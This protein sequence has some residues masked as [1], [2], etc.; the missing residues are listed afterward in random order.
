[1]STDELHEAN[2]FAAHRGVSLHIETLRL[3]GL[4]VT[5]AQAAQLSASLQSELARLLATGPLSL[6]QAGG[7]VPAMVA[8]AIQV[9]PVARA[10]EIGRQIARSIYQSLNGS[11]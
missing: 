4:P 9:S 3:H 6:P 8:P 5:T 10:D 1:M 11:L 2:A 7:A